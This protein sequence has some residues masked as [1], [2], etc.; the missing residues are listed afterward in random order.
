MLNNGGAAGG[1]AC[2]SWHPISWGC[3]QLLQHV[4]IVDCGST[5]LTT[6]HLPGHQLA[7]LAGPSKVFVE[8]YMQQ[9][10]QQLSIS[11]CLL[12]CVC[13]LPVPQRCQ[14]PAPP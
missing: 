1:A 7:W 10:K 13:C 4:V 14:L 3:D 11:A 6:R 2:G 12:A 5:F 9:Q 8:P